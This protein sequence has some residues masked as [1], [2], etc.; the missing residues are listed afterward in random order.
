MASAFGTTRLSPQQDPA[1][2]A[3]DAHDVGLLVLRVCLG[4]VMAAHGA[5]KLFGW[6][7]GGGLEGTEMF[8]ESVGYPMAGAM[9]LLT[10]VIET[11]GGLAL[12]VG[13]LTPLAAAAAFGTMLNAISVKWG[14]G[15]FLPDGLEYEITLAALAA[16]IA[17]TGPGR[18]AIDRG[19]PVLRDHRLSHGAAAVALGALVAGLVLLIRN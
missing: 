15:F 12:I 1:P 11:F 6:F 18:L 4:I 17:L 19:L 10:A 3:P 16:G 7:G 2:S 13:L 9:A 14:G 5:Q 8:F